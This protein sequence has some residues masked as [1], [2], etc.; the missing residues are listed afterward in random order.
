MKPSR[1]AAL[2]ALSS[3]GAVAGF[4][5]SLPTAGAADDPVPKPVAEIEDVML[6]VNDDGAEGAVVQQLRAAFK[7]GSLSKDEWEVAKARASIAVEAGNLLLGKKPPKGADTPDGL[8]AWKKRVLG[9]RDGGEAIRAAA[10]KKDAAAGTAAVQALAKQC[11]DC[12][13]VHQPEEEDE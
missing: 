3:L 5:L 2:L 1:L 10:L 6:T 11:N 12:H 7:K 8:A 13:K 4:A 9:Y